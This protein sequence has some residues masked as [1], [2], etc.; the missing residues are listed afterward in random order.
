MNQA[1]AKLLSIN[2]GTP[3]EFEYK[4]RTAISA[5]WKVP[6]TGRVAAKGVNLEG[7][8]QADREAHGGVDKA[9]YA[10]AIED[11]QWWE[12]QIE[13]D[14]EP[15]QFGEN[16]T[17]QGIDVNN[18]LVGEHWQIG[19]TILEVSE[20]RIPCWRFGVR[21]KDKTFPKKFT[22]ALR[23]GTYLRIIQEGD[24]GTGDEIKVIEK[25]KH[26]LTIKDV[27][28]IYTKDRDEAERILEA[29]HVSDAWKV[30]AN[31]QLAKAKK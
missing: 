5:I 4:G 22:Q 24:V 11:L 14:I 25:P 21:M 16:L 29:E 31:K 9:L 17:T 2:V 8:D 10:Y 18:A 27:F 30:W 13:Q 12:Q 6:V 1:S 7:D 28:R 15:G 26:D 23:P 3:R 20:P 19:S